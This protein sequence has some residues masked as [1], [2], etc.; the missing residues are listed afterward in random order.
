MKKPTDNAP[1]NGSKPA[2]NK[3]GRPRKYGAISFLR[4]GIVPAGKEHLAEMADA[5][6]KRMADDIGGLDAL[7]GNQIVI[8]REVRQLMIFKFIVDERLMTEGLFKPGT[9]ELQ[10]PM[11]AFYLSCVNSIIRA[12]NLLGLKKVSVADDL[13]SYLARKYS[14]SQNAPQTTISPGVS[15]D[16]ATKKAPQRPGKGARN[17]F[18]GGTTDE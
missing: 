5:A 17:Q 16:K 15:Q 8:L 9:L 18:N 6:I 12:C 10:G 4:T 13:E 1:G 11:N 3:G 14:G 2:S 7:S